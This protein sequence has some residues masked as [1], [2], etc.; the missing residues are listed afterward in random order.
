MMHDALFDLQRMR[1]DQRQASRR[2][3]EQYQLT[4]ALRE[5][6]RRRR[7]GRKATRRAVRR[8]YLRL[9]MRRTSPTP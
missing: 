3:A 4:I 2:A 5:V 6:R 9:F 1:L 8:R 7:A